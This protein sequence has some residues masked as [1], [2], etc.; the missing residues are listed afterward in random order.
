M[1]LIEYLKGLDDDLSFFI[2]CIN[3]ACTAFDR[4][5]SGVFTFEDMEEMT[6][7]RTYARNILHN[8]EATKLL[9]D[10][11]F[12]SEREE[13]SGQGERVIFVTVSCRKSYESIRNRLMELLG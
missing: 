6:F 5:R 11:E 13:E 8:E 10:T 12:L 3:A 7:F 1:K 4:G 2:I 9:A